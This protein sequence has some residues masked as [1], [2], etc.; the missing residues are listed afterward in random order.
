MK[1]GVM[2]EGQENLTWDR[3]RRLIVLAEELG[4][5]SIWRSDH[6]LSLIDATRDSLETWVALTLAAAESTRLIFGPLVS[7]ITF[8]HPALLA[9]MAVDLD[10]LSGG[11]LV[12][13]V[14]A[15]WNEQEHRAF[16]IAFPSTRER[17]ERLEE[18]IEVVRR[19]LGDGP[20]HFS[21]R[22]YQLDGAD[23]RPKPAPGRTIPIL[24]GGMGER[25]ALPLVA[26]YADEWNLTTAS[27]AIY[28]A[29]SE[30]LA[31][32]CRSIGRDPSEIKRSVAAGLLIGANA[33]E[34]R[35]RCQVMQTLIPSLAELDTDSVP[36]AVREAG[37][38]AG[39]PDTIVECLR[40]LAAE[41][42]ERAMLQLNDH[43]DEASLRLV[44]K[45][46]MPVV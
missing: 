31:A 27:P 19:L 3:W 9:K 32:I 15:G 23:P 30:R 1:L 25:R 35:R 18:G 6:L 21:G 28:R 8:R 24:L 11:R 12:L 13:G 40:A 39:T 4:F 33:S 16:G 29:R 34:L 41:G 46:V 38:V 20:A 2:V 17:F 22:H 36:E 44:A 10:S 5:E 14:G 42:V 45:E 43:T 26:R 7:P 37:W